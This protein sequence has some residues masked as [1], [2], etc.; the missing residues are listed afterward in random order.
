MRVQEYGRPDKEAVKQAVNLLRKA[1]LAAGD[2][3]RLQVLFDLLPPPEPPALVTFA[4]F[5]KIEMVS[6]S[7]LSVHQLSD[8]RN[9]RL[10]A[11]LTQV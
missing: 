6:R 1:G 7:D 4:R 8:R 10:W 3:H 11:P 2:V 5:E 9:R